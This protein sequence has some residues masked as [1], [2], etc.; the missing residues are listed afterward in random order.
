MGFQA[1]DGAVA[2]V[3]VRCSALKERGGGRRRAS[4]S[5]LGPTIHGPAVALRCCI[6]PPTLPKA[7]TST[8]TSKQTPPAHTSPSHASHPC[9]CM[10]NLNRL[11]TFTL[12][13]LPHL[14]HKLSRAQVMRHHH[15]HHFR[16]HHKI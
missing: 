12:V 13:V 3:G 2:G 11:G 9:A 15:G 14:C 16:V 4:G 10:A 6:A 7:H 8:C 5:R 1:Q